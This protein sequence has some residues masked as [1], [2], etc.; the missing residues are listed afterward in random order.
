M[1]N[2][3][4]DPEVTKRK[5]TRELALW[6]KHGDRARRGWIVL[7]E[8]ENTPS[9]DLALACSVS[10]G[11]PINKLNAV[12]CAIRLTYE[13]YDLWPP[14][15]A[16]IDLFSRE[17]SP[18][19]VR[20]FLNTAE[21]PRDVL[22][23]GHPDTKMP[24]LCLP[25]I[26]EYH[27]HPQHTGDNWHLH[28]PTKEGSISVICERVWLTMSKNVLGL[29]ITLQTLPTAAQQAQFAIRVTQGNLD[30]LATPQAPPEELA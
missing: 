22:V 20:A 12:V 24:F 9:V 2:R 25:G 3:L 10:T 28:R 5:F 17:P 11:G 27:S 6:K 21:G 13:N 18:P 30:L 15:L 19:L 4:V 23:D 29:M 26:R 14:S 8:D 1:T 7:D 16:F